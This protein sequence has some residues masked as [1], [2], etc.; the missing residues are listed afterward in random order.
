MD[1]IT[2]KRIFSTPSWAAPSLFSCIFLLIIL[3]SDNRLDGLSYLLAPITGKA[4]D[5]FW[6]GIGI[7]IMFLD[8]FILSGG[9]DIIAVALFIVTFIGS[10]ITAIFSREQN[11]LYRFRFVILNC[12]VAMIAVRAPDIYVGTDHWRPYDRRLEVIRLVR[13]ARLPEVGDWRIDTLILPEGL[14]NLSQTGEVT[15]TDRNN[16]AQRATS[17]SLHVHFHVYRNGDLQYCADD[18]PDLGENV[19]QVLTLGKGWYWVLH[20]PESFP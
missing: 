2:K 3:L 8:V 20:V 17:K 15:V 19:L 13:E 18:V 6:R 7:P 12:C 14:R 1:L 9:L 4:Y 10:T 16:K 5:S 11:L